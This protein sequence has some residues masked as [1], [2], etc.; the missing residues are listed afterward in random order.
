MYN[1]V[2]CS[3]FKNESH[4]LNEWISHYLYHGADHIFLVNDN[5][6]D[7]Y[8]KI[9]EKYNSKVTLFHNDI[10]T[11]NVGRQSLINNKYF[12]PLQSTSKWLAILDMDEFLYSPGEINIPTVLE[13]YKEYSQICVDWLMFGS[14]GNLYQPGSVCEGFKT[15]VIMSPEFKKT[16]AYSYKSIVKCGF[17][18]SF[19]VHAH[20]MSG[21][22]IHLEYKEDMPSD[23]VINHYNVQSLDFY[24]RVKATR[25][26][27][28]NWFNHINK[29]RD[30]ELF[31]K[32]DFN[33]IEDDRL[34]NQNKAL[35]YDI[36]IS[37][38]E[39]DGVTLVITSCNRPHLLEKTLESFVK[40][41]TFPITCAYIIDDSGIINCNSAVVKRF[42]VFPIYEV[43]NKKNIGQVQSI[44]KVY[45]YVTTP[46]IFHCEEDWE[47][48]REGFIEKS[49]R[50]LSSD[51]KIFTVWLRPH[52][53][54]SGHPIIFDNENKG[55]YLMKKDFSYMDKGT[56]YTWGGITFN[57]GLRKTNVCM[58]YHPYTTTCEPI[59][60]NCK[61][62]IGEYSVN[63]KYSEDGYYSC[64]LDH[65]EGHV[66]HIG[67]NDHIPR[68]WD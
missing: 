27:Q 64:I 11:T 60:L 28:D 58:A 46:Y 1:F 13:K 36:K 9:I 42:T 12:L 8:Q 34:Y 23:L 52:N 30:L 55:Y 59:I 57:P 54:T 2:V 15:R 5:S 19:D 18:N 45:S 17:I 38:I 22:T 25:G 50:V 68:E 32:Y 21:S 56:K 49:L 33:D 20:N 66:R 26:D 39:R 40:Y 47:F 10:Q 62:Y 37:K 43:Y 67:W 51:E 44:D 63:K 4:I 35:I 6:T 16:E 65:P 7:D 29:K 3:V 31:N 53:D 24:M 48:I 14:N 41:N 61:K